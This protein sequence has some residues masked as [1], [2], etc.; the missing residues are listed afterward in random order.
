MVSVITV[1]PLSS[2]EGSADVPWSAS[3][4]R[5]WSSAR[6][7]LVTDDWILEL[8]D[9][10]DCLALVVMHLLTDLKDADGRCIKHRREA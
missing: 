2:D 10:E 9:I 3:A 4:P 7:P 6:V 8:A 1:C 5:G